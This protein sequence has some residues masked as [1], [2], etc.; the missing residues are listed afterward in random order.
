MAVATAELARRSLRELATE[1]NELHALCERSYE[2]AVESALQAGRALLAAKE[3]VGHGEWMAWVEQH[4]AGSHRSANGYM[5]LA[6]HE[7]RGGQIRKQL[8]KT[9]I[10]QVLRTIATPRPE[11]GKRES[12]EDPF[13]ALAGNESVRAGGRELQQRAES[14]RAE[15][16]PRSG[17]ERKAWRA[18]HEAI[19]AG[20]R[21]FER[22]APAELSEWARAEELSAAARR[23]R[24]AAQLTTELAEHVYGG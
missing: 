22:A 8:A 3:Q 13:E 18:I 2:T 14:E 17:V 4:F 24:E 7:A 6:E 23:L 11:R 16:F 10:E 9:G 12:A 19:E 1:A 5:R 15:R 21:A 20:Q